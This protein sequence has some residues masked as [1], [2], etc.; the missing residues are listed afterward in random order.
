MCIHLKFDCQKATQTIAFFA[1]R[2]GGIIDK[3][4][5][6][7][8]VYFADRYH[9][10]KYG[11][12]I[13]NDEYFAMQLGPV[14]S[15]VKD[16][17]EFSDFLGEQERA[18]ASQYLE[19]TDSCTIKLINPYNQ[20]FLSKTDHEA[21]FFA[22]E[23]FGEYSEY[24]LS[25]LTHKYPEWE[26]HKNSLEIYSRVRMSLEDFIEDPSDHTIEKCYPLSEQEKLDTLDELRELSRIEALWD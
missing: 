19:K 8:L 7:K 26:K 6:L 12:L 3:L 14:A 18:Y 20:A 5:V 24:D 2:F 21:L 1:E 17:A 10:R 11:R 23:K 13:T 25:E 15:G 22:F 16:I 9:L 4:K